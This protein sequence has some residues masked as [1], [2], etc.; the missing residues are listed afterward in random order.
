MKTLC[1]IIVSVC[2]YQLAAAQSWQDTLAGIEKITSQYLPANPGC[3]LTVSRN[4]QVIFSKA[5]GMADLERSIP[6]TTSSVLEAGSVSKQFTSAAILLLEQQGKLS[7]EDDVRK[8]IPELPGYRRVIKLRHLLHHTSGLRDWGSVAALSG[9]PRGKKFY[10][11][12]DALE[13]IARQKQL[14]NQPGAEYIYSNSNFNLLAIIVQRVS[15]LSLAAF[16]HQYI[17]EPA[18]MLHTQW[19]DDPNRI[20]PNRAIAYSK[21]DSSYQINMPNEYVYGNGGLLTTTEDLLKW[22]NYYQQGHLG[23]PSLFPKQIQTEPLNNAVPNIYAAGLFIQPVMGW[24]NISHSGATAGY[25]AYLETFPDLHLS[26]ALLSNNAQFN[27]SE[28]AIK[29]HRLFVPDKTPAV[30]TETGITLP[31]TALN[32]FAGM[33]KNERD[34][35]T[36]NLS[37]KGNK[38]TLDNELP[39]TPVAG[40]ILK[41]ANFQLLFRGANG[42]YIP[43][44]PRDTIAFT[45]VYPVNLKQQ[46]FMAYEGSYFSEET[47]SSITIKHDGNHLMVQ[48]KAGEAYPLLPRYK[49]G[50][51]IDE[52]DCDVQFTRGAGNKIQLMKMSVARARNVQ[53]KKIK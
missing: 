10:T 37:V 43:R 31:D 40:N 29:L 22:T 28:L 25:R 30:Q 13:I 7:L 35:S 23:N 4:E 48:L 36:F 34:G 18:G 2:C 19:R 17:F 51:K 24:N 50:F 27:I 33:Y 42:F 9:W 45:K 32:I 1:L 41:A 21:K 14:N 12:D 38:I 3:Q 53:F 6:L 26:F 39:L 5:W 8:Y 11:N 49:Y 15:G 20:V 16:T 44:S 52:L 46:D 47:N